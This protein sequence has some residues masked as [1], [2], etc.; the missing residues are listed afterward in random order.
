MIDRWAALLL[1]GLWGCGEPSGDITVSIP[2]QGALTC[3]STAGLADLEAALMIGGHPDCPLSV[4]PSTLEASGSCP[5]IQGGTVRPLA[6]MYTLSEQNVDVPLAYV[7]GTVNLCP[8]VA[9]TEE[10]QVT[11]SATAPDG[12]IL[13]DPAGVDALPDEDPNVG[14]TC[15]DG[16][17]EALGW[18]KSLILEIRATG[19]LRSLDADGDG[20]ANLNE[21][22]AEGR[23]LGNN[24]C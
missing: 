23:A 21:V 1:L 3:A 2:W 13:I 16:L 11:L 20:C 5:G 14:P 4:D 22:C 8:E 10:I 15:N 6:L 12:R 24:G 7:V 9:T 17:R 18:A 19:S